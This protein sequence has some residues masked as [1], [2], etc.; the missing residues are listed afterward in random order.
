[1]LNE[2]RYFKYTLSSKTTYK[3][4][5]FQLRTLHGDADLFVSREDQWP[6]G[7]KGTDKSSTTETTDRVDFKKGPL[8]GDYYVGVKGYQDSTFEIKV[9]LQNMDEDEWKMMEG[10][11]LDRRY[12]LLI[13]GYPREAELHKEGDMDRY[14]IEVDFEEGFEKSIKLDVINRNQDYN[15]KVFI[16]YKKEPLIIGSDLEWSKAGDKHIEIPVGSQHYHRKGT[17]YIMIMPQNDVLDTIFRY[18]FEDDY[19]RYQI[20]YSLEGTFEFLTSGVVT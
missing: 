2:V 6:K 20:K 4:I 10:N 13:D 11:D 19:Y 15:V 9:V 7:N 17:Y 18:F 16:S 3:A 8:Q 5:S 14:R 1:M 12:Q